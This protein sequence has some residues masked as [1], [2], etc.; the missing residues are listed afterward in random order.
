MQDPVEDEKETPTLVLEKGESVYSYVL[1]LPP[2][3]KHKNGT[4][5]TWD[6]CVGIILLL[7]NFLMQIG[8]TFIVGQ[9]VIVE[10][11]AWRKTLVGVQMDDQV[12]EG[13]VTK[14]VGDLSFFSTGFEKFLDRMDEE[15]Y[16]YGW[17]HTEDKQAQNDEDLIHDLQRRLSAEV[18]EKTSLE[19]GFPLHSR[20]RTPSGTLLEVQL[21]STSTHE[22]QLRASQ[23]VFANAGSGRGGPVTAPG[24]KYS[25][26]GAATLCEMHN[27]KYTC[28][29]PTAK[30]ANQWAKLDSNGDGIWSLEEA[31]KD[32]NG[33]ENRFKAKPFLVFRAITVG[34]SDRGAMDSNLWVPP[35]MKAMKAIPKPLFDY[36]MGDA[37]LCTYA[38][39]YICPTLLKRGFFDEA[40]NPK[41]NGKNIQ[42][43]DAALD[44]CVWML[45][46]GGGC[47]QSFPQIYKLYRARRQMQ[48]GDGSLF[49]AGLYKNPNNKVD[50]VYIAQVD[51]GNLG[52]HQKA[53]TAEYA[54]FLFLVL[55]LWLFALLGEMRE[56]LKLGEYC[57]VAPVAGDDGGLEVKKKE[58]DGEEIEEYTIVGLTPGHRTACACICVIRVMVVIYLGVVGCIF[59]VMETGYMDLLMNAVALAFILEVDEILFGSI[60]RARTVE[61][62]E[63]V[64]EIEFE[65]VLPTQGCSGWVLQK[66]F[67]GI[68]MFPLIAIGLIVFHSLFTTQPV[69]D[70]LNCACYQLGP[71]CRDADNYGKEWW[72]NY[73]SDTLPAAMKAIQKLKAAGR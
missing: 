11:N 70:A 47:E 63:S 22:G 40:M 28:F 23:G 33:F 68:I 69:L 1:Y 35:E 13:Q 38:D 25:A 73:W 8:L 16:D 18:A 54:F 36:W 56:M 10:G 49:N 2:I 34:L 31:E 60:A 37:I 51:Y 4:M 17:N 66:D 29:P 65:T 45:K 39:P 52:D 30:F 12:G 58:E 6:M 32:A 46:V 64:G 67:W 15:T 44:Y 9:G 24:I 57:I 72:D 42:D 19:S 62:L 59:L 50:K 3:A 55:L 71:Q 53:E 26:A 61:D 43:I 20:K 41:N 21:Q 14:D 27:A 5:Y 48:C 7:T